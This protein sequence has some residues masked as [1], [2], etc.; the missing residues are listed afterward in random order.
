[1]KVTA[2]RLS[3]GATGY[4]S[5]LVNDYLQQDTN[6]RSFYQHTP[7]W[8]GIEDAIAA[9]KEYGTNNAVLVQALK[10]QYAALPA[11]EAV[12]KA[13]NQLALPNTFT[14]TTA[15]QPAIFTGTLY[16]IYKI[17]HAI[18]MA[19]AAKEKWPAYNFV[20]VYYMGSED[21]DLDELGNI[22][23]SGDTISWDT[24][25]TGAVGR[26]NTKGLDKIIHRIE[27]ELSV[28]PYG[29][30]LVQLLKDCYL[31]NNT[32]VQAA[33]LQLLHQLFQ[34][35]GLVVL[36]PDNPAL[37]ALA[38]NV[39]EE[40]LF[41]NRS[42][43]IVE[44]TIERLSPQYKV[45]AQPRAINLFYL[46]DAIRNRIEKA[47]DDFV[48]VDTDIRF[49]TAALKE[50]LAQHPERFSP[51][52]ILRGLFQ[53]MILPNIAFIGGGGELAYWLE[54]KDLFAHYKVNLPVLLLRNSF[55]VIEK[56]WTD[57]ISKL[58]LHDEQVFLPATQLLTNLVKQNS[59]GKLSLQNELTQ[60]AAFYNSLQ[61]KAVAVDA[62]L[63][64]HI[65]ALEAKATKPLQQLQQKLLRSEKRKYENEQR[66]LELIKNALFPKNSLQERVENFMPFYA[67]HGPAFIQMLYNFSLTTEQEFVVLKEA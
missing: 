14:I 40:E 43:A 63:Q 56:K 4:F 42:A 28:Q 31:Q 59:N 45:Q 19:A 11:S 30:E 23:L 38:K 27:G 60:A 66:Q 13:I 35:Y 32:T 21:A 61:Q 41:N 20:P 50:E 57:K 3:Y 7:N 34:Q 10:E 8:Q 37:K 5:K 49:T 22:W 33:T 29:N 52:V 26:M 46:K 64:K 1:M 62:T 24:K 18:K 65:A 47:G 53:E 2:T 9:R 17:L 51:N 15:H 36:I 58:A 48:V 54:F 39:F 12:N 55:L 6:L 44:K 16:F 67:K 25:Q